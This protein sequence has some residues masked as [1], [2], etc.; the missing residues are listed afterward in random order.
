MLPRN[1]YV[2]ERRILRNT[3]GNRM[4]RL[5]R[6]WATLYAGGFT[7]RRIAQDSGW[8][9]GRRVQ[10]AGSFSPSTIRSALLDWG[11]ELRK[12]GGRGSSGG[13]VLVRLAELEKRVSQLEQFGP[14]NK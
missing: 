2:P 4:P 7:I 9:P 3:P 1:R 8:A 5:V 11:V 10:P 13:S 12:S 6:D 14:F